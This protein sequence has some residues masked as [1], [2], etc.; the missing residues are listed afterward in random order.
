MMRKRFGLKA[1]LLSVVAL[2][3]MFLV[4]SEAWAAPVTIKFAHGMPPDEEEPL[5]RGAVI[6]KK[7]VEQK[8]GRLLQNRYLSRQPAR[9]GKGAI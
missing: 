6:F 8:I 1:G 9:E 3:V 2:F 7:I 4:G 5:H